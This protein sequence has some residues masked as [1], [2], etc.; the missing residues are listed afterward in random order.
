MGI[1]FTG[2]SRDN[3][4][5]MDYNSP[6]KKR[7]YKFT[8]INKWINTLE[9]A[10]SYSIMPINKAGMREWENHKGRLGKEQEVI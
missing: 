8:Y 9:E 7:A 3:L 4:R 2:Q 5:V 6:N 10:L 1:C